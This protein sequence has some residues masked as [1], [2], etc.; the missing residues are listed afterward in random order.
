[1]ANTQVS[2]QAAGNPVVNWIKGHVPQIGAVVFWLLL[3]GGAL[4]YREANDLTF[5]EL[6]RQFESFI[7]DTWYGPL[8]YVLVY[9]LRPLILF[10]AS[11]LSIMAGNIYGLWWGLF[12]GLIAGTV[13]AI[14]PYLA[15]RW[16]SASVEEED[17]S[18]EKK[19]PLQR[20]VALLKQNP[21]Q[22]VLTMRLLFLP[23]DAVSIL[24]GSIKVPFL[25]FFLGT[26]AGNIP[27]S[28]PFVSFGA[29]VTGDI[30]SGEVNL[31]WRVLAFSLTVLVLSIAFSRFLKRFDPANKVKNEEATAE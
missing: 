21:F 16:F 9:F 6:A 1:M 28:I 12:W 27:G 23:Y 8:I 25:I 30:Y 31:D 29:S 19:N 13:S 2:T 15:G 11:L 14:I 10:P 26:L 4:L 5:P 17:E 22:A 24:A 3:V 18:G 7:A 20:F